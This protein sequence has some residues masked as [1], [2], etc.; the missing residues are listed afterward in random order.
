MIVR[1]QTGNVMPTSTLATDVQ[2][3]RS[4]V[5]KIIRTPIVSINS[6]SN[7]IA[8]RRDTLPRKVRFS[9]RSSLTFL[10]KGFFLLHWNISSIVAIEVYLER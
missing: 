6:P 3:E 7:R 10:R 2:T 1:E 4:R 5:Q 9:I 8:R